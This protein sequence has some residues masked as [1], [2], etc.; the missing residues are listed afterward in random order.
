M[1][2]TLSNGGQLESLKDHAKLESLSVH[3]EGGSILL[4]LNERSLTY[5]TTEE[6]VAIRDSINEALR[7]K[8]GL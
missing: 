2:I 7:T 3:S 4:W 8:L 1:A 6:A 5:L